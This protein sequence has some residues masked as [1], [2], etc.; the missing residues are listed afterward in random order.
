MGLL[1]GELTPKHVH[2]NNCLRY[3][4]CFAERLLPNS[5]LNGL[6]EYDMQQYVFPFRN[7]GEDRRPT[8]TF[9][10]EI[11]IEGHPKVSSNQWL[12]ETFNGMM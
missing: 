10:R 9:P 5:V 7:E 2:Q 11:P 3:H 6:P 1:F 4:L 12:Q 8:L